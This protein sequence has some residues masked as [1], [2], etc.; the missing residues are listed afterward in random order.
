MYPKVRAARVAGAWY[1]LLVITG[2]SSMVVPSNTASAVGEVGIILGLIANVV[3][4][5]LARALYVLLK[6]VNKTHAL[7]MVAFVL[8]SVG[9][10]TLDGL[11][12][13]AALFNQGELD[14]LTMVLNGF[15]FGF[16]LLPFGVLVYRSH[17]IPRIFGI[18]LIIN[19]FAYPANTL[20]PLI[21]PPFA[22]VISLALLPPIFVGELSILA[23]LLVKGARVES[24]DTIGATASSISP[25]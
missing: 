15:L 1:L 21:K 9:I 3:Y 8:V 19:G 24:L 14:A 18:L 23:W 2:I 4:I 20:V 16:W 22:N 12:K 25:G 11:N 6:G 5:F 7:L 17:F 13:F 10:S